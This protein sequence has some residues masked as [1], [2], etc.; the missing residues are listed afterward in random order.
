MTDRITLSGLGEPVRKQGSHQLFYNCPFHEDDKGH[1]G[2]DTKRGIYHC[3]KCGAKGK[4]RDLEIPLS[5]FK[6]QV[7]NFL[8]GKPDQERTN[9]SLSNL[10]L[11]REFQLVTKQS[12]LPYQYLRNREITKTEIRSYKMGYCNSGVFQDRV[13][14]P[15]YE[16]DKLKYFVGRTY[17]NREPKYMNAPIEKGGTVF[18]TFKGLV[19]RAIICEGIFDAMRIGRLFPAIALLGKVV[20]G[21]AQITSI[22][23]STKEAF[24]MLDR[25]AES[26]GFYA[27]NVLNYYLKTQVMFIKDKD[28]GSMSLDDLRKILPK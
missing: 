21:S 7:E 3:F 5:D 13:I 11:P 4:V 10:A 28:P 1:M 24:V 9:D 14:V 19:P 15:I 25:D 8:Y 20:N 26:Q 27:S 6:E 17:T 16:G 23:K 2:V 12:G 22:L 18:K